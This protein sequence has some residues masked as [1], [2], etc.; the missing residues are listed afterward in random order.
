MDGAML[1]YLGAGVIILTLWFLVRHTEKHSR[2]S[3]R[4]Q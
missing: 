2:Y 4:H 3:V 1:T